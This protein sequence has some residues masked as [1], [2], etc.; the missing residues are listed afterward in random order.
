MDGWVSA[1]VCIH[2]W[3]I[4]LGI[5]YGPLIQRQLHKDRSKERKFLLITREK[6]LTDSNSKMTL[7]QIRIQCDIFTQVKITVKG[8]HINSICSE[9]GVSPTL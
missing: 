6:A 4:L 1:Q 8:C 7:A 5:F 9:T 3:Q 2:M